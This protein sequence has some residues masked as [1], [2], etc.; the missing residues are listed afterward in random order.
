M[1]TDSVCRALAG[2]KRQRRFLLVFSGS[3]LPTTRVSA[4]CS[5]RSEKGR[6][7]MTSRD[8]IFVIRSAEDRPAHPGRTGNCAS[9]RAQRQNHWKRDLKEELWEPVPPFH[10]TAAWKVIT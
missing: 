1:A 4:F 8:P 2:S 5:E 6:L 7:G 9:P 10:L 3:I